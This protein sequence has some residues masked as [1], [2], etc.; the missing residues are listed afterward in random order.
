MAVRDPEKLLTIT[1]CV[2]D[3]EFTTEARR[4]QIVHEAFHAALPHELTVGH[5]L[6]FRTPTGDEVFAD[7]FLGDILD[8]FGTTALITSA[9][10]IAGTPGPWRNVG[11]DHLAITVA[12]RTA[13]RDFFRD[14]LQ[15][16]VMRHDPHLTVLAT[17]PT[18]LFL[19]DAGQ[20]APLSTGQ[21]ST[22]HHLGFVVDNLEAA[23]AHL[24]AHQD[25]ILS[26]FTLLER[27]E[28]WSLYFF[29]RNGDVT[30]M[31]QFSEIKNAD[32]GFADPIRA[33]SSSLLYD[34]A[35]RPYG[36]QWDEEG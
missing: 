13:A 26:D 24:R 12:D 8:H 35:S 28:R 22:W 27:D 1:F 18:A 14:V 4:G 11:F 29:Y 2:Q 33:G 30:F 9:T 19:F 31:I 34:Y 36:L 3:T 7:N 25:R 6:T 10:P 17:G 32:R 16:Q 21:P 20:E 5:R 23:Y 15:M